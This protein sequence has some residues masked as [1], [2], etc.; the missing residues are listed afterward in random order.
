MVV[1]DLAQKAVHAH[2]VPEFSKSYLEEFLSVFV[3]LFSSF[4]SCFYAILCYLF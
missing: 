2:L 4:Y 3:L 1:V